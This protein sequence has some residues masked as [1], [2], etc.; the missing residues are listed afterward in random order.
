VQ[1]W[2]DAKSFGPWGASTTYIIILAMVLGYR[3][4]S[5]AWRRI[6]LF[7]HERGAPAADVSAATEDELMPA[8][9]PAIGKTDG[10][11]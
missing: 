8:T 6:K 7:A 9:E 2:P 10:G 3:W 4:R 5:G 11:E 1:L